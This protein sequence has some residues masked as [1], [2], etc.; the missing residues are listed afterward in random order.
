[1]ARVKRSV[2]ARKKRR[3]VLEEAKGYYGRKNSSYKLAKEQVM[4]SGA[5][6]YRD[7]RVRKREFRRLW[8]TRIN[9]AARLEG[10]SYSELM[11][12][13]SAAGVEVNRKMLAD[14][15]VNDREDFRRFV[16]IAREGAAA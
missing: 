6:A 9:A 3:K 7:R 11:H 10:M 8:I 16:E 13:L 5:Y 4:R 1:M 14:I 12:G 2:N 15:A